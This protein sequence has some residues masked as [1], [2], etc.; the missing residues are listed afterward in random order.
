[1]ADAPAPPQQPTA[2]DISNELEGMD[3]DDDLLRDDDGE[4]MEEVEDDAS[5]AESDDEDLGLK[6]TDALLTFDKHEGAVYCVSVSKNGDILSGG[7]DDRAW[8]Q[9]GPLGE[10][11]AR[12][13]ICLEGHGDSVTACGFSHDDAMAAT[14]AYDG[15][16]KLWDASTGSLLRTLEGPGDVEWLGWHPKGDVVLCGACDGTLWMWLATSGACMRVFAGH[17]GAVL[18]G[19]FT[20]DGKKIVSGSADGSIRV[21]NPRKGACAHAFL[22][23]KGGPPAQNAHI[24]MT[25]GA[26]SCLAFHPTDPDLVLGGAEDGCGVVVHCSTKRVLCRL[27]HAPTRYDDDDTDADAGA[28]VVSVAIAQNGWCATGGADGHVKVWDISGP[29]PRERCALGTGG[30]VVSIAWH[31]SQLKLVAC[32]ADGIISAWDARD[33]TSLIKL[34]GHADA[35]LCMAPFWPGDAVV[36]AGDDRSVCVF[37]VPPVDLPRPPPGSA[38]APAPAPAPMPPAV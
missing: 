21:W 19:G 4:A 12:R 8:L 7:G 3:V 18:C 9:P 29:L 22:P 31:P 20:C 10:D 23:H 34:R 33:G 14:G 11:Q 35:P 32:S 38:P 5:I 28:A 15:S 36:T 30:A 16:V 25:Q 37:R 2:E 27:Q 13:A 24:V 6:E 17:D 26:V 1:M